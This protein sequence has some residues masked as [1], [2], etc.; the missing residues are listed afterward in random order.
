MLFVLF[1]HCAIAIELTGNIAKAVARAEL[2]NKSLFLACLLTVLQL[3]V[4]SSQVGKII[5]GFN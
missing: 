4:G 3:K 1:A 2:G 5:I